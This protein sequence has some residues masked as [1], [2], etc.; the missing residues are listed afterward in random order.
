MAAQNR[1]LTMAPLDPT[2]VNRAGARLRL[3]GLAWPFLLAGAVYLL[4]NTPV[5]FPLKIF[6]V[7]LHELSHGLAA[8]ATGGS[9]ERIE[10]SADQGGVCWTRGGSRFLVTSAGYLGSCLFGALFVVLGGR[11]RPGLQRAVVGLAGLV[12]LA[13]TFLWIRTAFGVVFGLAAAAALLGTAAWLS[14]PVSVFVLRLLGITSGLYAIWDIGSDLIARSVPSSDAE[15]L[16]ALTGIPG[17]V[18][19]VV[20]GA[21]AVVVMVRA[22]LTAVKDA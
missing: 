2:S 14:A 13:V 12:V 20:W 4:W 5:L 16:A 17:A 21:A 3:A 19:G 15:A 1:P 7:F 11:A 6:T 8:I 10:L 18:W 22:V 9:I